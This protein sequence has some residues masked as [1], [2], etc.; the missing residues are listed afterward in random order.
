MSDELNLEEENFKENHLELDDMGEFPSEIKKLNWGAFFWPFVWGLF[1]VKFTKVLMILVIN[2][3]TIAP[4]FLISFSGMGKD[5]ENVSLVMLSVA[6]LILNPII[7]LIIMIIFLIKGNKW[8]W[9]DKN[10]ESVD[11]FVQV[12]KKWTVGIFLAWL[13]STILCSVLPLV[14][15]I[16]ALSFLGKNIP[17]NF[18][19]QNI[20]QLSS[21][22]GDFD[23]MNNSYSSEDLQNGSSNDFNNPSTVTVDNTFNPDASQTK[24]KE[25]ASLGKSGNNANKPINNKD[26]IDNDDKV[27][28]TIGGHGR[29]NPFKP[30]YDQAFSGDFPPPDDVFNIDESAKKLLS[31]KVAG[32]LYDPYNPTNASAIVNTSGADYM[33]KK[34]DIVA[35]FSILG[36]NKTR[37]S[38]KYGSNTYNAGIGETVQAELQNNSGIDNINKKFAGNTR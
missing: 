12:Q 20:G 27:V 24:T 31:I 37:V 5:P 9:V 38:L 15:G 8:S 17:T 7:N 11:H 33:V 25:N 19:Q 35:G 29:D 30:F 34:G 2:L 23:D 4:V 6:L 3:L 26:V 32:I 16:S 28:I 18:T 1:N 36:I 22:V 10:W 21:G 14:L 13:L